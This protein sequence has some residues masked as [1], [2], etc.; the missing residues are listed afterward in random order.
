MRMSILWRYTC[1]EILKVMVLTTLVLV[2]VVA[3]GATIKPLIQDK[4]DPLDVGK[5]AFFAAVPMLQF[6]LPFAAGFSATIVMHRMANDNEILAMSMG[7]RYRRIF[8]PAA[9]LG[10]LLT[11]IMFVLVNFVIPGSG[12]FFRRWCPGT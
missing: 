5:Y 9:C 10:V 1:V 3:F 2:V 4:I 6:A 11:I 12:A 8:M 7:I